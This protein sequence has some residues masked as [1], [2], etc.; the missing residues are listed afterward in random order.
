ME[1][2]LW[3]PDDR[4]AVDAAFGDIG[5]LGP[6]A[7]PREDAAQSL[8]F[9]L[10]ALQNNFI[11]RDTLLAAFNAWVADKFQS[12]GQILLDRG[13][14]TPA[15]HAV[16]QSLGPGAPPAARLRPPSAASPS[17]QSVPRS[18]TTWR[19]FPTSTFRPASFISATSS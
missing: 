2:R 7:R 10:L 15:R 1:Y 14:S 4:A 16:L 12:L 19:S 8:L 9:G 11:D 5:H 13:A 17:W 18:V 6:R 3:F